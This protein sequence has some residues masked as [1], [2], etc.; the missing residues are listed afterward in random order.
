MRNVIAFIM[1]LSAGCFST[2]GSKYFGC[3][4]NSTCDGSLVCIQ[5]SHSGGVCLDRDDAVW[6][7]GK[8]IEIGKLVE[9]VKG[10]Q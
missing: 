7:S 4:G 5:P 1:L 6:I 2:D 3:Y 8:K 10:A 9:L